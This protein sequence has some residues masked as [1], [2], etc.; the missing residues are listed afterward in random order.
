V[1]QPIIEEKERGGEGGEGGGGNVCAKYTRKFSAPPGKPILIIVEEYCMYAPG[2]KKEKKLLP[3]K[4]NHL[5]IRFLYHDRT[6]YLQIN[7]AG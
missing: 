3:N 2:K 4:K 7:I 5:Y 6:C 1:G